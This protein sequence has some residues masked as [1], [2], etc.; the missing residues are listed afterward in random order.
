MTRIYIATD[1]E[2]AS[3]IGHLEMMERGSSEFQRC[4]K[5]LCAD[6]NA[7]VSGAFD[8][9]ATEPFPP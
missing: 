3:G 9:G 1:M 7:A 5:L 8:G 2:G 6:V 4:R